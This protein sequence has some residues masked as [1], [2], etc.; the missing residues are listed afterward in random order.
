MVHGFGKVQPKM[1]HESLPR[2]RRLGVVH[3]EDPGGKVTRVH[4]R[5]ATFAQFLVQIC[6]GMV[7]ND[8]FT[9]TGNYR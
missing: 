3:P 5:E 1:R 9:V 8:I 2:R 6:L 7:G 4:V